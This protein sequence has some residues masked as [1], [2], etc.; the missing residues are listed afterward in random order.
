MKNVVVIVLAAALLLGG[1]ISTH[2]QLI[3]AGYDPA[4]ADGFSD[5]ESS[6]YCAANDPYSR[7]KKNTYRYDDDK[8]YK[9]GWD[10]GFRVAKGKYE[11][12]GRGM[13]Y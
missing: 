8:Q 13:R 12:T 4:Y 3:K 11:N 7:F 2:D 1:C 5:G 9:Q 10:D 6:G